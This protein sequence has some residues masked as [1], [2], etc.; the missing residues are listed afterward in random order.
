M[1]KKKAA[2]KEF[3]DNVGQSAF[4]L[5]P[6]KYIFT[7][8]LSL[9]TERRHYKKNVCYK[10]LS[11]FSETLSYNRY[12]NINILQRR[13]EVSGVGHASTRAESKGEK[14]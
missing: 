13:T 7:K 10:D 12:N 14:G 11:Q 6:S 8:L 2:A 3:V 9:L 1:G 5:L 4:A